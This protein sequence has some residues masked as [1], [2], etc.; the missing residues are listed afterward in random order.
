MATWNERYAAFTAKSDALLAR[1]TALRTGFM[2]PKRMAYA[3][4][5]YLRVQKALTA[6]FERELDRFPT[7]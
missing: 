2:K 1:Y 7:P 4:D 6:R 5:K 3:A